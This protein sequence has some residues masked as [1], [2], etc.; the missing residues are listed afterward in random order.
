MGACIFNELPSKLQF[1]IIFHAFPIFGK[2]TEYS[3]SFVLIR[4]KKNQKERIKAAFFRL[5]R[6]FLRLKGR[7]SLRSNSL[8]FLTLRYGRSP[9][10]EKSRPGN[11]AGWV[12]LL[13]CSRVGLWGSCAICLILLWWVAVISL[14]VL[15]YIVLLCYIESYNVCDFYIAKLFYKGYKPFISLFILHRLHRLSFY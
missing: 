3:F 15:L 2:V 13:E 6:C 1:R 12:L 7:N 14:I 11:L 9:D 4:K 5:L 10:G 8:P